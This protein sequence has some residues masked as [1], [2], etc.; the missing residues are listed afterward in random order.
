[1]APP[2]YGWLATQPRGIV[3]EFPMPL[4]DT[5]PGRE[6]RYAYM[7]TFHWM[8]LLN[9]YS[10]YYPP[11]YLSMLTALR[12]FPDERAVSA[13]RS[14]GARY[15]IVHT[16]LYGPD[17]AGEVLNAAVANPFLAQLGH[18]SDGEGPAA[19]FLLR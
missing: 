11:S 14:R 9:G 12:H 10:G 3:A 8:P 4:P 15:I 6:P 5:L 13:L 7:S 18:F 17:Q 16:S 19:V 1:M 2:L